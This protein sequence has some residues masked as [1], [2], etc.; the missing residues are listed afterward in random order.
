MVGIPLVP[1]GHDAIDDA[2]VN[3]PLAAT[4]F[5]QLSVQLLALI[6]VARQVILFRFVQLENMPL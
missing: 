6:S 2:L 1:L 4:F 3:V 5:T